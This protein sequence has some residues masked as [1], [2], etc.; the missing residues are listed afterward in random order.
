MPHLFGLGD[1]LDD[2]DIDDVCGGILYDYAH[3]IEKA[4]EEY[5]NQF[6]GGKNADNG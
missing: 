6:K 4:Y 2:L 3:A 5:K 1:H